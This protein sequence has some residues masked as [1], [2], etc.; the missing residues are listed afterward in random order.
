MTAPRPS[1][2]AV[3]RSG[4][5]IAIATVERA[6]DA[7][8]LAAALRAGGV[9]VLEVTL[10]TP[11]A[12]AA[13]EAVAT[14]C[15]DVVVGAGTVRDPGDFAAAAAAGA[16]FAVSPGFTRRLAAAARESPLPWL[17]GVATPS[18]VLAAHDAGLDCLKFFPAEAAGGVAALRAF[19]AVFPR[20]RFCPTG[21]ID[22]SNAGRYLELS[23]VECVAGSW[24]APPLALARR[25]FKQIESLAAAAAALRR[26][27]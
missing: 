3:L 14:R 13:I 17:P 27:S 5:V 23:N 26:R 16:R 20:T 21:G 19:A 1:I 6:S 2:D 7:P 25:D 8:A 15:A 24:L 9:C 10:R 4:P 12:L 11:A 18:E 22:A